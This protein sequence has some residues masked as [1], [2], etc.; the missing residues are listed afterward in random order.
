MNLV[1]KPGN[2][3][4]KN[5]VFS[6]WIKCYLGTVEASLMG[7]KEATTFM[8]DFITKKFNEGVSVSYIGDD[9]TDEVYSYIVFEPKEKRILFAYTKNIYRRDG[10]LNRLME[11]NKLRGFDFCFIFN[12]AVTRGV[13]E[14]YN[15]T[16]KPIGR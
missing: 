10:N 14:K 12:G 4:M 6:S 8:H 5:F 1:I 9:E 15:L 3:S 11:D 7:K 13:A 2:A 16:Y